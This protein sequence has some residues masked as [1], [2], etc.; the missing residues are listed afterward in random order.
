MNIRREQRQRL[1]SNCRMRDRGL[2]RRATLTDLSPGGCGIHLTR[3]GVRRSDTVE[4][5][6]GER[7]IWAQVCWTSHGHDAGLRFAVPL[8]SEEVD[9]IARQAQRDN[10]LG[11]VPKEE[12]VLEQTTLRSVC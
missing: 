3:L 8:S 2:V 12:T 1:R 6:F 7:R 10:I 5:S 11:I 4:V 9:R